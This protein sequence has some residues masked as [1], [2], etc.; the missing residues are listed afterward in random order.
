MSFHVSVV[1]KRVLL[2]YYRFVVILLFSNL[3]VSL[4][5]VITKLLYAFNPSSDQYSFRDVHR[6]QKQIVG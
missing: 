1:A 5:L 4:L 6:T 3:I 2:S